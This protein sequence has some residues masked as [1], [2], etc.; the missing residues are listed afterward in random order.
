MLPARLQEGI[1]SA[2]LFATVLAV[3]VE[4]VARYSGHPV[5]WAI[6]LPTYF[7]LWAFSFAAGLSDW[8]DSQLS[9]DLLAKRMPRWLREVVHVIAN[10]LIIVP[11]ALVLP[12]TVSFISYASG[13]PNVGLPLSEA[14]GE[15]GIFLMFAIGACLR[16]RLVLQ[17]AW[18]Y[19]RRARQS[20]NGGER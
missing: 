12:G 19:L 14:Y 11:F 5:V 7:F 10:L 3:G 20:R 6:E 18:S 9:F 2:F 13:Q 15:A 17:L 16:A 1:G 8:D 4:V